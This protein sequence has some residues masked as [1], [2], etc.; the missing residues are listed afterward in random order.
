MT[1]QPD[2][3][4]CKQSFKPVRIALAAGEPSGDCLAADLI[5]A[6][7]TLYPRAT[8][9]GM[10]GPAMRS[11]GCETWFDCSELAVMGLV[12][13]LR[14][15]PRLLVLRHQLQQQLLRWQPDI[16]I[17]IDAPDFNL[18]ISRW[19]KQRNIPTVHY[20]SPSIWA[21]K[22]KRA[23]QMRAYTDLVLCLFPMEPAL[24]QSHHVHARFVG[25]PM[26]DAI[27]LVND[28]TAARNALQL[29]GQTL[30]LALL[31]G[32][33]LGEID[34]LGPVFLAAAALIL[35]RSPAKIH[36]V[37]AA[38][39]PT[40]RERI[41]QQLSISSIPAS[42]V[43]LVTGNARQCMAAADVVLL[44]SGTATL[45]AMLLKRPMVV[46]YKL[47]PL[48]YALAKLFRLVKIK[49]VA[50]PNILAATPLIPE[51]IQD[52][53][54]PEALAGAVIEWFCHPEAV[55]QLQPPFQAI[56]QQLRR[57]ASQRA[58]FAIQERLN[59]PH[60]S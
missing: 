29:P 46:G 20:V 55:E 6:L 17:G 42:S 21:W 37:V 32:S 52:A 36:L 57:N 4:A 40:C 54:T 24:Y 38:A 47:M 27:P 26:A 31:P 48:T 51:F 49:H 23:Q 13:V 56:H 28:Q 25:H 60:C 35:Q 10:T 34:R 3:T 45:E 58:A 15:L 22:A 9:A 14:R 43:D 41:A 33:R 18:R 5:H 30:I 53:C 12:E 2:Q 39:N 19:L 44:A 7:R 50:L 8:F 11:A 16:F 59:A 1:M